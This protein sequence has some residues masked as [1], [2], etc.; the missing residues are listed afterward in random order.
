MKSYVLD[1]RNWVRGLYGAVIGSAANA[2]TVMIIAPDKFNLGEQWLSLL[3]FVLVSS[4]VSAALY[5]KQY[6]LPN[7][8]PDSD[9]GNTPTA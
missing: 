4:I 8:K 9:N 3:N 6:P 7:E 5:L 1:W 2:I